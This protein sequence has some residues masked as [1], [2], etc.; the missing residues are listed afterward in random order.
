MATM[1]AAERRE[2]DKA[3]FDAYMDGCP[4][5]QL[6][7]IIG[8]KW[9]MLLLSD[10][11]HGTRRYAEIGRALPGVSA[12]MLTQTLRSLERDGFVARSV[13]PSVPVQVEYTL[14]LLGERIVP[15]LTSIQEWAGRHIEEIHA[16][17]ERYGEGAGQEVG[18][19]CRSLG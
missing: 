16:A 7:G 12:K 1:T 15:L 14:T 13:T 9:S 5:H 2:Q 3:A 4:T 17:R 10:L 11:A 8:N 18:A 19:D 6:M